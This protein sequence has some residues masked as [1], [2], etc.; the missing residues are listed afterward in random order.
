MSWFSAFFSNVLMFLYCSFKTELVLLAVGFFQPPFPC[1][2]RQLSPVSSTFLLSTPPPSLPCLLHLPPVY[3]TSPSPLP[4]PPPSSPV[5]SSPLSPVT[6]KGNSISRTWRLARSGKKLL[7]PTCSTALRLL[8]K[9][10]SKF[11]CEPSSQEQGL[12]L[13]LFQK[14]SY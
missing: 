3:S 11:Q 7:S 2:S 9:V 13:L 1:S 10:R 12:S 8:C 5:S 6:S 4:P 14:V